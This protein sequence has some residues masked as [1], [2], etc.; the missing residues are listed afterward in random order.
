MEGA[1][2]M[3]CDRAGSARRLHL[4]AGAGLGPG[5]STLRTATPTAGIS[6]AFLVPATCGV[7]CHGWVFTTGVKQT[8]D[9]TA[10]A[11]VPH[12]R[13]QRS[14]Y[15][16]KPIVGV[17]GQGLTGRTWIDTKRLKNGVVWGIVSNHPDASLDSQAT[18]TIK[19][20]EE[21]RSRV[22]TIHP[23]R[24]MRAAAQP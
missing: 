8:N 22:P 12:K 11:Y 14:W 16:V 7:P 1:P 3:G 5:I 9:W 21:R 20:G 23:I 19:K 15:E 4:R 6:G 2:E 24:L 10:D 17:A 18:L 13:G